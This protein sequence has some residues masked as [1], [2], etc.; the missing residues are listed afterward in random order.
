MHIHESKN[1]LLYAHI[2]QIKKI[3]FFN[4]YEKKHQKLL[5]IHFEERG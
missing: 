5:L 1:A 2:Q 3:N 4:L